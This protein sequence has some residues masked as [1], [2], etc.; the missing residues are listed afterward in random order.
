MPSGRDL[1]PLRVLR[2]PTQAASEDVGR[3]PQR[4]HLHFRL[5]RL[6]QEGGLPREVTEEPRAENAALLDR[7]PLVSHC[8][9]WTGAV[10]RRV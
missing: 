7:G 8:A 2:R 6:R 5:P 3:Q 4:P 1:W 9:Y 10:W